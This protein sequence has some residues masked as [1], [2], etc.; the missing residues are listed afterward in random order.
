MDTQDGETQIGSTGDN[1]GLGPK[2]SAVSRPGRAVTRKDGALRSL[3]QGQKRKRQHQEYGDAEK[4]AALLLALRDGV[5]AAS[6]ALDIP[7]TTIYTWF[8]RAGGLAE[9]RTFINA[10]AQVA[11]SRAEQAIYEEVE[12]RV[13]AEQLSEGELMTTF[14][15]LIEA[16]ALVPAQ[17]AAAQSSQAPQLAA[18][19]ATVTL[20][21][22][23]KDGEVKV[24]ELG[25]PPEEP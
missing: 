20:Q 5:S 16:R 10:A 2:L 1:G 17:H 19:Q 15:K 18:A 23:E 24:I 22:Q 12:R 6:Q 4:Q 7:E 11:L 9:I 21:V 3:P 25:P 14:G 13:R 8:E